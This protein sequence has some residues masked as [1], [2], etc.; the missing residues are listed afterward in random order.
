MS[1][2]LVEYMLLFDKRKINHNIIKIHL[3]YLEGVY[4]KY[5]LCLK[6][7]VYKVLNTIYKYH[8][9]RDNFLHS[10]NYINHQFRLDQVSILKF[11]NCVYP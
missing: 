8:S 2:F 9:T 10:Q 3:I 6:P 1:Y 7:F 11:L 5:L 4:F